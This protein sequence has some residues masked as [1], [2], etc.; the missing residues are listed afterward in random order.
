MHSR[1]IGL[2]LL[3]LAGAGKLEAQSGRA[4]VPDTARKE[5][6][7]LRPVVVTD[8]MSRLPLGF[9]Q[10]RAAGFGR[11]MDRAD[12]E[13]RHASRTSDLFRGLAGVHLAPMPRGTGFLLQ[14]R[15]MAGFCQPTI[16]VDGVPMGESRQS[17]DLLIDS[18]MIEAVEVYTSVSTAPV[19]YAT[20]DC[21]VVLFWMRHIPEERPVKPKRWKLAV[22]ASAL[23]GILLLLR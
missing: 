9:E 22:G 23:A 21:G 20:G 12:I 5:P 17:I 16:W 6:V 8:T 7:L 14:V 4:A 15:K 3:A 19:Q 13:K 10:R 2:V 18:N 11:F 1:F